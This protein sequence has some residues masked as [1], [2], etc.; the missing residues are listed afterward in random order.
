MV[1]K[2]L[3]RDVA[4]TSGDSCSINYHG[5]WTVVEMKTKESG[6]NCGNVG[7][8]EWDAPN[9]YFLSNKTSIYAMSLWS[10]SPIHHVDII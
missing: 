8:K 5:G 10:S 3:G 2:D 9:L 6:E 7:E 1:I 4:W